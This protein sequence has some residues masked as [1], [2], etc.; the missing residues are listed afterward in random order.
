M[1]LLGGLFGNHSA[2]SVQEL[3]NQYGALKLQA[4]KRLRMPAFFFEQLQEVLGPCWTNDGFS[5]I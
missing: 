3:Q 4:R 2:V 1:A 5:A